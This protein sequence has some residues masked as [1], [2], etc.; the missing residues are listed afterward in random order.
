[1]ILASI[2]WSTS[3]LLIKVISM[4]AV[5]LAGWRSAIAGLTL[6][7]IARAGRI[8][9]GFPRDRLSWVAAVIYALILLLFVA[10]TKITAAAN[11]IFLQYT[12]PIY[13][14]LLE[15]VFL[16]TRLRFRDCAF[17]ALALLGMSLFFVGKV[18]VGNWRGNVM[19][20]G[21][22][23]AFALFSLISRSRHGDD[24]ARWQAVVWGNFVLF[25]A[26][27]LFFLGEPQRMSWPVTAADAAGLLFLG[28]VQIGF[29][30]A[31]FTYA[32]SQISALETMLLAMLEPILNPLWVY[33]G[34]GEVPSPRAIW[35]GVLIL[36]TVAARTWLEPR[37]RDAE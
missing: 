33:F 16:K 30:Y 2:L 5:S 25:A 22:G 11:V 9:T 23:L 3:G 1:M 31:L 24:R 14:L 36:G 32:I 29:A 35:G 12:A 21:S 34:T 27:W 6:L 10:A 13:V 17:V 28:V 15:P 18:E 20:L 37:R 19:A 26:M 7:L 8:A 4:D